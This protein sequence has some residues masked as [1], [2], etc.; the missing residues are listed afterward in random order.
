M[1]GIVSIFATI[2]GEGRNCGKLSTFVRTSGCSIGCPQCDTDYRL[3][4]RMSV[5]SVRQQIDALGIS[6]V[7]VTGG[8][9]TD[10]KD[11]HLLPREGKE[12][13]LATA[14]VREIPAGK[15]LTYCSPHSKHIVYQK[16]TEVNLVPGLNGLTY[17]DC[18][19]IACKVQADMVYF[20]PLHGDESS[21][22]ECKEL[23]HKF[24]REREC[25]L[26]IQAHK[27]WGVA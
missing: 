27:Y 7:W 17:K 13:W 12:Y 26:G 9:P 14:G 19:E 24:C 20:T 8:E 16:Y 10:W 18:E 15:W 22:S 1:L 6:L 11:V 23:L 5:E 2:Q 25:R 4:T 3:R 21:L